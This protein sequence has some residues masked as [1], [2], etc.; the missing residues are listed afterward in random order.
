[1]MPS[2][3][4][5]QHLTDEERAQRMETIER[6]RNEKLTW[7]QIGE[8]MGIAKTSVE[9]WY[10]RQDRAYRDPKKTRACMC[11]RQDFQSE[12]NHNRL[13]LRCKQDRSVNPWEAVEGTS[14]RAGRH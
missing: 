6:F 7:R 13:C 2:K 14:R 12:G 11:C 9:S 8:R 10:T 1:M 3:I 5:G 4:R